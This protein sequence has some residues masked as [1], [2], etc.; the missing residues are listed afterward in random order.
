MNE[1]TDPFSGLTAAAVSLHEMFMSYVD[2]GFTRAESLEIVIRLMI[3]ISRPKPK[4]S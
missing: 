1:P 2:A 3:G 4:E